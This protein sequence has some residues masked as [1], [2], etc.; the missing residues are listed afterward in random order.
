MLS[1]LLEGIR[2]LSQSESF[3]WKGIWF[4]RIL[5]GRESHL[6]RIGCCNA[7]L[8][9]STIRRLPAI[10]VFL[11]FFKDFIDLRDFGKISMVGAGND[12]N[13]EYVLGYSPDGRFEIVARPGKFFSEF[14]FH[15]S[16]KY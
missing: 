5:I 11:L 4:G 16:K 7:L 10:R 3:S 2:A 1:A 9:H 13:R 8:D 6:T 15:F 14:F 12:E